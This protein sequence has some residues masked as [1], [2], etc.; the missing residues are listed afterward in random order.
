MT[1]A[2]IKLAGTGM[3]ITALPGALLYMN[4]NIIGYI[5]VCAIGIGVSFVL[6]YM[7]FKPTE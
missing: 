7:F 5:L 3:G 1:A 6:T 4:S 2:I